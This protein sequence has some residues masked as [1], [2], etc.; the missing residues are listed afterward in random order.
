M[1]SSFQE[2]CIVDPYIFFSDLGIRNGELWIRILPK[3]VLQS[4]TNYGKGTKN[5]LWYEKHEDARI[6]TSCGK[7]GKSNL[8]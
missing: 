7:L 6:T 2:S 3:K 8:E 5:H 1:I 4:L